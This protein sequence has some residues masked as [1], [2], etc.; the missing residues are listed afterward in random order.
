MTT[1]ILAI[2]L[3]FGMISGAYFNTTATAS[4]SGGGPGSPVTTDNLM[5]SP[6]MTSNGGDSISGG[7]PG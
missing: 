7:G 1:Y 6:P 3:S 4:I 5:G 2:A